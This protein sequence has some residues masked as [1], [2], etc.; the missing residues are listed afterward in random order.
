MLTKAFV[1]SKI[2]DTNGFNDIS[3]DN[4]EDF[5]RALQGPIFSRLYN[6]N[7]TASNVSYGYIFNENKILGVPRLR[8]VRVKPN[9]CQFHKE[10][11]KRNFTQG[12]YAEYTINQE[13]QNSFGNNSLNILTSNAWVYKSDELT[14]TNLYTGMVSKYNDGGFIQLFTRNATTTMNI[15]RELEKNLWINRGTRAI[16]FDV[17]VY[18]PNINLF[19]HIRLLAEY[20]SSGICLYYIIKFFHVYTGGA[21]PSASIQAVKLIQYTSLIDYLTL[22]CEIIFTVI[23][24]I[25]IIEC[26][27]EIINKHYYFFLNLWN[28]I[29]LVTIIL[30]LICIVYEILYYYST[31]SYLKELLQIEDD[32]PNFNDLFLLKIQSDYYLGL[33][34]AITWLKIFKYLNLN[35]TMLLLNKTILSCLNDIYA[36][37]CIFLIIFLAYTL[38]G[39]ILFGRYLNEWRSF[40]ESIFTLFRMIIGDFDFYAMLDINEILGPLFLFSYIY[41]VYFVLLNMFLAIINETYS[42][43]ESDKTLQILKIKNFPKIFYYLIPRKKSMDYKINLKI[44]GYTDDDIKKI[45]NKYDKNND[46]NLDEE[47]QKQMKHDLDIGQIKIDDN[48]D[49]NKSGVILLIIGMGSFKTINLFKYQSSTKRRKYQYIDNDKNN[50]QNSHVAIQVNPFSQLNNSGS[51]QQYSTILPLDD[52]D[53]LIQSDISSISAS[54]FC[55]TSLIELRLDQDTEYDNDLADE[56]NN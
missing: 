44:Q 51:Y 45:I 13:D 53:E 36:F 30:A 41:F 49:D 10:F 16:F 17:I 50:L 56:D 21:I 47:E 2:N 18:N 14:K 54:I 40:S 15:L 38:F 29:N 1:T 19:C 31:K 26:T 55:E 43:I 24:L 8:Q 52:D 6:V 32:Y 39:W 11:G 4:G 48:H 25:Q 42:R 27:I 12:C 28:L 35:K 46:G 23:T 33:I 9:S 20:L 37:T 34:L 3:Q 7:I 5:W 22:I